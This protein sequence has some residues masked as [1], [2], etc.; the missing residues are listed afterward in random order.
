MDDKRNYTKETVLGALKEIA[1]LFI[2]YKIQ[3][4]M[5]VLFIEKSKQLMIL[6]IDS[7]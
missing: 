5:T 4:Q 7:L 1:I 6:F 2:E 3:K